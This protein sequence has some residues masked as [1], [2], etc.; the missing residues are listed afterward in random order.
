MPTILE[1]EKNER[2]KEWATEPWPDPY[3]DQSL[4]Q[5]AKRRLSRLFRQSQSAKEWP[6]RSLPSPS[7]AD[8]TPPAICLS[9][10]IDLENT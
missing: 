6:L 3:K 8:F 9:V 5:D 1:R 10:L 4:G 7:N 2:K